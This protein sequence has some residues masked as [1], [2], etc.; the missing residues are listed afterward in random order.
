MLDLAGFDAQLLHYFAPDR[1]HGDLCLRVGGVLERVCLAGTEVTHVWMWEDIKIG[2][3]TLMRLFRS[4]Q[5]LKPSQTGAL[6]LAEHIEGLCAG[7][8]CAWVST[9]ATRAQSHR[10]ICVHVHRKRF[11]RTQQPGLECPNSVE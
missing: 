8:W 4:P 5:A 2:L 6:L 11:E 7:R 1:R 3:C 9:H 10:P